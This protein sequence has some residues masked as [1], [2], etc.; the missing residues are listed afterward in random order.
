MCA[1][2]LIHIL[3]AVNDGNGR[4]PVTLAGDQPIAQAIIDLGA[5]FSLAMERLQQGSAGFLYA[6]AIQSAAVYQHAAA[7]IRQGIVLAFR[8]LG[9]K[10]T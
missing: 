5:A 7:C 4:T 2:S 10:Y 8:Y 6:H 3:R 1:L 9:V